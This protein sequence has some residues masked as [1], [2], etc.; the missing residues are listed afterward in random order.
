MA[1]Q[2]AAAKSKNGDTRA[3]NLG[4]EDQDQ[5]SDK[6]TRQPKRSKKGIEKADGKLSFPSQRP[7][8]RALLE[9]I[10]RMNRGQGFPTITSYLGALLSS[11]NH[12]ESDFSEGVVKD[13]MKDWAQL[14]PDVV[15]AM[16]EFAAT[17]KIA[18][19]SSVKPALDGAVGKRLHLVLLLEQE[20]IDNGERAADAREEAG[21]QEAS[22]QEAS[23]PELDS[24]SDPRSEPDDEPPKKSGYG[25]MTAEE[26]ADY[27]EKIKQRALAAKAEIEDP[28]ILAAAQM[29]EPLP[30]GKRSRDESEES[31]ERV[32]TKR[33]RISQNEKQSPADDAQSPADDDVP[34]TP[35]TLQEEETLLEEETLQDDMMTFD[36]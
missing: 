23:G 25:G 2:G 34:A 1:K 9:G 14:Q 31:D 29:G 10:K 6:N 35:E 12:A 21:G 20:A 32:A 22:G 16:R 11:P 3:Q 13:S 24:E 8:Y 7:H 28:T 5:D 27:A 17:C 26:K 18:S 33:K 19:G 4:A 36:A 30:G 15:Q